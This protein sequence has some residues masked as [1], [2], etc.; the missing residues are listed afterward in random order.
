MV[1]IR[2]QLGYN[3]VMVKQRDEAK[4][5]KITHSDMQNIFNCNSSIWNEGIGT[6]WVQNIAN[7]KIIIN[8]FWII[9]NQ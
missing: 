3:L 5:D 1:T 8:K 9:N 4:L 2:L 6:V 7:I